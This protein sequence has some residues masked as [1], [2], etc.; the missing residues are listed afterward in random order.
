[1]TTLG[2]SPARRG[3]RKNYGGCDAA[4]E[5]EDS[6]WGWEGGCT[7]TRS[8]PEGLRHSQMQPQQQPGNQP[9]S[10]WHLLGFLKQRIF[11]EQELLEAAFFGQ[12]L[13]GSHPMHAH[14]SSW[15]AL[16][17]SNSLHTLEPGRWAPVQALDCLGLAG[18]GFFFISDTEG[19]HLPTLV[20]SPPPSISG[21]SPVRALSLCWPPS[22][23]SHS[24]AITCRPFSFFKEQNRYISIGL[25]DTEAS[26][27]WMDCM[28]DK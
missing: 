1:M 4:P 12:G 18:Q 15:E 25:L 28:N 17:T 2:V 13:R 11:L 26:V 16:F 24:S 21:P 6:R 27:V 22:P 8:A 5:D 9:G 7:G 3:S 19:A 10:P 20:T 23:Y 14:Q